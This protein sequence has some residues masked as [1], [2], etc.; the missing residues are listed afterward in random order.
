[1]SLKIIVSNE[2]NK[3][4]ALIKLWNQIDISE[5]LE[6][7]SIKDAKI[8]LDKKDNIKYFYGKKINCDFTNFPKITQDIEDYHDVRWL[9]GC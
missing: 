5:N 8:L 6:K 7:P 4:D 9:T 1:M 2:D 3:Y